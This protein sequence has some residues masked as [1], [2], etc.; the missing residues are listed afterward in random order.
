MAKVVSIVE[1]I[2]SEHRLA[3]KTHWDYAHRRTMG[4]CICG[5][6][7]D[8][9]IPAHQAE[10]VAAALVKVALTEGGAA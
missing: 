7:V 8:Y 10:L 6:V 5:E 2:L 4:M 1:K 9:A 3:Y